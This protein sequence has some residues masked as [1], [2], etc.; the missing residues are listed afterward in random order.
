MNLLKFYHLAKGEIEFLPEYADLSNVSVLINQ[1]D[2]WGHAKDNPAIGIKDVYLDLDWER[3]ILRIVPEEKLIR[4]S[5]TLSNEM[6]MRCQ[7]VV[8]MYS[9][10]CPKCE[11]KVRLSDFY[12]R[13]CGQKLGV[14]KEDDINSHEK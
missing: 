11:H 10:W 13:C 14:P 8:G 3:L 2:Q 4:F 12:C 5:N 7:R 9:Y 1:N 6:P